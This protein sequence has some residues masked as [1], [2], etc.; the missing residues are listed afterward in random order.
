MESVEAV[1]VQAADACSAARP[2]ARRDELDQYIERM[3]TL[4]KL[5]VA[6]PGVRRAVAMAAGRE[7]RVVVEPNQVDDRSLPEVARAIARH[8]EQDLSYPG[9]ITVTVIRE[10]R[11]S[12]TAS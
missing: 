6:H 4:E 10:L 11:V 9:E 7:V 1:L 12:A 8:I 5:V 3:D 2:G